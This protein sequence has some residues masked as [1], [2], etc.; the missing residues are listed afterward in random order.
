[1]DEGGIVHIVTGGGGGMLYPVPGDWFTA[2]NAQVYHF[3]KAQ[4]TSCAILVEAIDRHGN[5]FDR[6]VLDKCPSRAFF[7]MLP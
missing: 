5:V 6:A 1:L 7:P 2:A 3:V 4:V